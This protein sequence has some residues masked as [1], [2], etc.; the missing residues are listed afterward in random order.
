[1]KHKKPAWTDFI[2]TKNLDAVGARLVVNSRYQVA[3]KGPYKDDHFGLFM[4]LSIKRRDKEAILD[5]R[6]M[7]KIKNDLVGKET[8]MIQI[9]PPEKHLVDTANQYYFYVFQNYEFPFGFKHRLVTD[10]TGVQMA[11]GLTTQRPF[12]PHQ[13]PETFVEDKA[14]YEAAIAEFQKLHTK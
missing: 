13:V 1:M 3:M 9:F 2:V 4:E 6:D 7:Q 8:T 5:W 14:K 10:A 11:D 12:E